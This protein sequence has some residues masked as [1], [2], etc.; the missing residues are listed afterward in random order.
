MGVMD[1]IYINMQYMICSYIISPSKW[2][3]CQKKIGLK[4]MVKIG[5][6]KFILKFL[7]AGKWLILSLNL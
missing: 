1:I 6:G 3:I 5:L 4:M 7:H 2:N